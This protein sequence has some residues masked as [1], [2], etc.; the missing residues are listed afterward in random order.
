MQCTKH[1]TVLGGL[2]SGS[3][4]GRRPFS[5]SPRQPLQW[6]EV[7]ELPGSIAWREAVETGGC[8]CVLGRGPDV[9]LHAALWTED[10]DKW[11]LGQ[12]QK[13]RQAIYRPQAE[14]LQLV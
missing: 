13:V 2:D 9:W 4:T 1:T 14:Q 11:V 10:V 12:E 8:G 6:L 5:P 7:G 3:E